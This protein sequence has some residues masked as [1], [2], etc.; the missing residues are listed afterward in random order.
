MTRI[1]LLIP[2]LFAATLTPILKRICIRFHVL[3]RQT[4]LSTNG[5]NVAVCCWHTFFRRTSMRLSTFVAAA[6]LLSTSLVAHASDITFTEVATLS[7]TIGSTT[8]TNAVVTFTQMTDTSS[9]ITFAPGVYFND[10]GT[11]TVTIAGVGTATLLGT[12]FGAIAQEF[13][14]THEALGFYDQSNGFAVTAQGNF[15]IGY[16]L[17]AAVG[18]ESGGTEVN[19]TQSESTSLGNL[20][21]TT[22]FS[23][24]GTSTFTASVTPEP[25]SFVLLG[26]GLLGI[27]GAM[28]RRLA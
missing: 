24:G 1:C 14:A 15:D 23:G 12:T 20:I 13:S 4:F 11:S 17:L 26:T 2:C 7:G 21:I 9:L 27:A 8:F 3:S 19:G 28:R 22:P 6:A 25:S 5:T 10:G 16:S 18:P